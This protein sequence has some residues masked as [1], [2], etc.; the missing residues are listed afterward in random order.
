MSRKLFVLV[1]ADLPGTQRAVQ[2]AHAVATF[3][4]DEFG[5]TRWNGRDF[6]PIPARWFNETLVFLKTKD[7]KELE[8]FRAECQE[9]WPFYEPDIGG[10]MTAFAVLTPPDWFDMLKLL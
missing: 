7:L 8:E 1:R 4:A 6:E 2:A 3:C 5:R 9:T 10:E